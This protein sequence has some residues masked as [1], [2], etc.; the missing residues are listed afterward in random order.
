MIAMALEVL[1]EHGLE[2]AGSAVQTLIHEAMQLERSAFL[3]AGPHERTEDRRGYGGGVR[4]F[5]VLMA[6][7]VGV[8]GKRSILDVS[9]ALSEAEVHWQTFLEELRARGLC[10]M[11]MITS[12]DHSGSPWLSSATARRFPTWLRGSR[13]TSLT[14]CPSSSSRQRTASDYVRATRSNT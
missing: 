7:G 2:G 4:D 11:R 5:A 1:T 10:G 9:A 13:T 12:D 3:E 8:D 14:G 6:V